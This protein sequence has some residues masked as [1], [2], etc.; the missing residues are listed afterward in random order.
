[1]GD[2]VIDSCLRRLCERWRLFLPFDAHRRPAALLAVIP[3]QAGI[4]A[5]GA[6]ALTFLESDTS[7]GFRLAPE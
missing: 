5:A 7:S 1:V 2:Y 3:A 6:T 4:Q